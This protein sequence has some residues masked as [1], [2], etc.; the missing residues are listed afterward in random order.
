MGQGHSELKS[1]LDRLPSLRNKPEQLKAELSQFVEICPLDTPLA[2]KLDKKVFDILHELFTAEVAAKDSA[3]SPFDL[4]TILQALQRFMKIRMF[5]I[6][7]ARADLQPY[8]A[9]IR[10]ADPISLVAA[11]NCVAWMLDCRVQ[12]E[13]G[14][15]KEWD[16]A[17]EEAAVKYAFFEYRGYDALCFTL[18]KYARSEHTNIVQKVLDMLSL[19]L[20][21]HIATTRF[22]ITQR[23][24]KLLTPHVQLLLGLSI[25][26]TLSVRCYTIIFL[27]GFL[28]QAPY[29][30]VQSMQDVCLKQG[31]L[32]WYLYF[33][34]DA[35]GI[36][37]DNA[38]HEFY[39]KSQTMLA[40]KLLSLM[41]SGHRANRDA[42]LAVIPAQLQGQIED[43]PEGS[44]KITGVKASEKDK[45]TTALWYQ[46]QSG[47]VQRVN[48][49]H[50]FNNLDDDIK[51]HS[52]TSTAHSGGAGAAHTAAARAHTYCCCCCCCCAWLLLW[53]VLCC[54]VAHCLS[55]RTSCGSGA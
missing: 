1:S 42:V 2:V 47:A 44:V 16:R 22:H 15:E 13:A 40:R 36:N 53:V 27:S 6:N 49:E 35:Q 38:Y 14:K 8:V 7:L 54:C 37:A 55:C 12:P 5:Y 34:I 18:V 25:H 19:D 48:C 9:A 10:K 20:A 39:D 11:L 41:C 21:D 3:A 17:K 43:A 32:L 28:L 52:Q 24:I 45:V 23:I 51:V 31:F 46:F 50:L 26:P 33:S 29:S 30:L 4:M